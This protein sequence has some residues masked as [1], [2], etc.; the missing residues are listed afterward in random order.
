MQGW[1]LILLLP[2]ILRKGVEHVH[3]GDGTGGK[4]H[5]PLDQRGRYIG[6]KSGYSWRKKL[7]RINPKGIK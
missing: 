6:Q 3:V 5:G 2:V 1:N 7:L 4:A